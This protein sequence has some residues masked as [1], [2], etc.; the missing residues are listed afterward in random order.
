MILGQ[1][2][3]VPPLV[4]AALGFRLPLLLFRGASFDVA[5]PERAEGGGIPGH[6]HLA[7]EAVFQKGEVGRN[8]Y[9]FFS[10]FQDSFWCFLVF[11][12]FFGCFF[13]VF[14]K[15]KTRYLFGDAC[16][17]VACFFGVLYR[18]FD[19]QPTK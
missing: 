13:G 19:S 4:L 6:S 17:S 14:F 10:G 7:M 2:P 11:F 1:T 8:L 9:K 5:H 15:A 18:G 16:P 12:V 3:L